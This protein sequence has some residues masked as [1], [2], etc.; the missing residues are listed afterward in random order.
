MQLARTFSPR[1]RWWSRTLAAA[2]LAATAATSLVANFFLDEITPAR[3]RVESMIYV[4]TCPE[5]KAVVEE[6]LRLHREGVDPV[7]AV[8]G[9]SGWPLT[10]YWRATPVW[11]DL[12]K[13]PMHPP[14][15]LCN[16]EQEA[17]ARRRLGPGY[18][19]QRIPL[20][21]WWLMEDRS[22]SAGQALRY[23][24]ARVPWSPIGSSD[25]IVLRRGEGPVEW[26]RPA[27]IP[28]P[29]AEA[30]PV[31]AAR[32][33]GE[34]SLVEPR[35]LTVRSDGLLAVADVQLSTVVR[36][37]ADG[38][39]EATAPPFEL[40]QPEAV[41]WT[42]Q[43]VLAIADTWGQQV[44]IWDPA[45]GAWR[46][47][48]VPGEGWYGPRGVAVAGDGTVAVTDTG[49][50]R[51]ALYSAAEGEAQASLLGKGGAQVGE[52]VE[53]VGIAWDGPDRLVV[54]D[55]GNRR[56]QVFGRDGA[57]QSVVGLADA[58]TEF[59]SRPQLAVLSP[60]LWVVTDPPASALWLVRE[61]AARRVDL[62]GHGITPTGVAFGAGALYVADLGGRVWVFD[63]NLDS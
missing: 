38:T 14:I 37:A 12:P 15:V 47:L 63:L 24:V 27:A 58:W 11:W 44:L 46:A 42:P 41:A 32:V 16:P 49:N 48:P 9:E 4:Q 56:L 54:C 29:L 7:A 22:P 60:G 23:A 59:Y 61:G 19:A 36:F 33:I 57:V 25:V 13:P 40:K 26:S 3:E 28:P 18:A 43:G 6:G 8:A 53:P 50:K 39:P 52:L 1:G 30:L 21:A 17:E 45:S 51:V 10:W 62:G 31:T 20:R 35:G 2:A 5:L 34:G 55:T